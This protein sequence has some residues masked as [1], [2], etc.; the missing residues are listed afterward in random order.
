MCSRK[1]SKSESFLCTG[2]KEEQRII[3]I[4]IFIPFSKLIGPTEN[5]QNNL[6]KDSSGV[7]PNGNKKSIKGICVLGPSRKA[8]VGDMVLFQKY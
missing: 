7:M 5:I 3:I 2:K 1:N 6:C 8:P 4:R